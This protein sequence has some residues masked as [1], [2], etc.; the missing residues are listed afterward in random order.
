M[1]TAVA[2]KLGSVQQTL[3]LPLWGRAVESKKAHPL[4]IDS[5]AVRIIDSIGY[6][7]SRIAA[8]TSFI[9]QLG[10]I[11]RSVHIDAVIRDFLERHPA[12]T[13]VNM[14][15]GLDTTFERVDN[16]LVTWY[17]I[18]LPDVIELREQYI[19]PSARRRFLACSILEDGWM[20]ELNRSQPVLFLAAGV[21]YYFEE[22][23]VKA[24][25]AKLAGRF[26][27]SEFIFDICSP[28]GMR[29]ANKRVIE[30]SGMSNEAR[31]RW[32]LNNAAE[33]HA[34]DSRITILAEYPIFRGVKADFSL[35]EKLGTLFSDMLKVN[36]MVHIRMYSGQ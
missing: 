15:C 24:L 33:L 34:W 10:W 19:Q 31:L 3:L 9:S 21:L 7:F 30:D 13:V 12:A 20:A 27:G 18:D 22:A 28:K 25:L 4:L 6:D 29:I 35:R 8:Q 17:D 32:A 5:E 11:A 14:G 23:Q 1:A 2:S 36:S 16:A 26:P